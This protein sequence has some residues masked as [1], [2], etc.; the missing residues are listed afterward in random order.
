MKLNLWIGYIFYYIDENLFCKD[1]DTHVFI[2]TKNSIGIILKINEFSKEF[3]ANQFILSI[4]RKLT[5]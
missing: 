5:N 4:N 2:R 3:L 1:D